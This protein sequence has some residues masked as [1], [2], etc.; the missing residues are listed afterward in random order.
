MIGPL[1]AFSTAI[2]GFAE[3]IRWN[4]ERGILPKGMINWP[5]PPYMSDVIGRVNAINTVAQIVVT[6][7]RDD[8]SW[9]QK[10]AHVSI[11]ILEFAITALCTDATLKYMSPWVTNA[12]HMYLY[13]MCVSIFSMVTAIYFQGMFS[14]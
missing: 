5:F 13:G 7:Q 9:D 8:L 1:F 6:S 3:G 2:I 10:L 4:V 11:S 12:T 14:P